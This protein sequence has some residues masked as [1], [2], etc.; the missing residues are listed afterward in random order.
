MLAENFLL[1]SINIQ[2]I[3][4]ILRTNVDNNYKR[5]G[6]GRKADINGYNVMGKTGTA[7]KPSNTVKGYSNEILNVF[8]SAFDVDENLYVLTVIMD[9]P[10]GA[11]KLWG[12][13]RRESGW[14]AGY[15]NGQIIKKIGPI[16]NTLK[17][18][19]YAKLN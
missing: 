7:E 13:N 3:K 6:S 18:N 5:G 17:I 14:N 19:D 9:E 2:K 8:V 12:H 15:I 11:P 10:K 1:K 16:L 4:K